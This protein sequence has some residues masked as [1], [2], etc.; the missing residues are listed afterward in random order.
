MSHL[1]DL[2]LRDPQVAAARDK[3]RA[4]DSLTQEDGIRLFDAPVLD[5]GLLAD[6]MA[7]DRHGDRVYF[8]VNRQLNPTNVCVL[9]CRFCDYAKKPG[10]SG[11][12]TMTREE[13]EAHVDPEIT[14]IHIVGGLHNRWRF[15]DYLDIVRWV[16]A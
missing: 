1:A 12:Y 15:D 16:K 8:T 13:I 2:R 6:A 4:G 11:A 9:A 7:R 3:L 5:L 10:A 14:E